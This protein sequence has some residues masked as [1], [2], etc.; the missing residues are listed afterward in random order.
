M[1]NF[2]CLLAWIMISEAGVCC[3]LI[4]VLKCVLTKFMP[5]CIALQAYEQLF[6]GVVQLL[7]L[8]A[9]LDWFVA[10]QCG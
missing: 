10:V 1:V 3:N 4:T 5:S 8:S 6:G 9:F 7:S 2:D